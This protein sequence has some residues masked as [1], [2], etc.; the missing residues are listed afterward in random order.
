M[1]GIQLYL[2]D[3][4]VE[5]DLEN[6][7]VLLRIEQNKLPLT[8]DALLQAGGLKL[9]FFLSGVFIGDERIGLGKKGVHTC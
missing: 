5:L 2:Y 8:L 4:G 1:L 3:L 9:I 6:G 7:L